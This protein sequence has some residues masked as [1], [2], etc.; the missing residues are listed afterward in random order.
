VEEAGL[1]PSTAHLD[2]L[3][4][5]A[6]LLAAC[7]ALSLAEASLNANAASRWHT[8][9]RV[10]ADAWV[11]RIDDGSGNQAVMS[12]SPPGAVIRGFDHESPLS[13][14]AR[15]PMQL[16]PGLEDGLPEALRRTPT[17]MIGDIE[18]VTFCIWWARGAGQWSV[19]TVEP[20]RGDYA[21]PD[22]SEYL[23]RPTSGVEEAHRFL[24]EYYELD[25]SGEMVSELFSEAPLDGGLLGQLAV[26]RSASD[27]QAEAARLSYPLT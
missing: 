4:E 21:D 12:F 9:E 18:S 23:L 27:V 5:P 13:P 26:R 17:I 19:G 7:R 22:G 14:W 11:C 24:T 6:D 1:V 2:R 20:P 25:L 8:L 10:G 15:E 16:W 3:A